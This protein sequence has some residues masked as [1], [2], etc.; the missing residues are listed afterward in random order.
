MELCSVLWG[1]LDGR[2]VPGENRY[3]YKYAGVLHC[4][5]KTITTLLIGHTSI[6][7]EKLKKGLCLG[8]HILSPEGCKAVAD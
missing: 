1:N 5:P 6:Q 2:E 8:S 3:M 7:N 4:L